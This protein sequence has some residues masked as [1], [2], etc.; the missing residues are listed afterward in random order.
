MKKI[1]LTALCALILTS[2][3]TAAQTKAKILTTSGDWTAYSLK[4]TDGMVCYMVS[5]PTKSAGKYKV[6]DDVFMTVTHRPGDKTYDVVSVTAG[7]TYKKGSKPQVKVDKNK[8]VS[9]TSYADTAWAP[10]EKTDKNLVAQMK[11]GSAA[12][13]S[14]T[15]VR[16]TLTTDTFSLKGFSKAYGEIEKACGR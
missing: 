13:L 7:Y 8:G 2:T 4:E 15:S 12:T 10:D 6:R 11:K 1:I 16:G 9:L 3:Q 5:R 14:G